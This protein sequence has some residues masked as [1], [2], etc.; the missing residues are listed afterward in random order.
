MRSVAL[1]PRCSAGA[2]DVESRLLNSTGVVRAA[3]CATQ[4]RLNAATSATQFVD[5]RGAECSLT[6][7][8]LYCI[9]SFYV[10]KIDSSRW[11]RL[12]LARGAN[13]PRKQ[14][15]LI[16]DFAIFARVRLRSLTLLFLLFFLFFSFWQSR[17]PIFQRLF[18]T[19]PREMSHIVSFRF[20]LAVDR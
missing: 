15:R 12:H 16:S 18:E 6:F 2:V 19:H 11:H 13:T 4:T 10:V 17:F 1:S 20:C 5:E 7:S 3:R 9:S 14:K 8:L